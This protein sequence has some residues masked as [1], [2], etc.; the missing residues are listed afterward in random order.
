MSDCRSEKSKTSYDASTTAG[1][2]LTLGNFFFFL[3]LVQSI[4]NIVACG[5][6][7]PRA[8]MRVWAGG[9]KPSKVFGGVAGRMDC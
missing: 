5:W 7:Y 2:C 8:L 3:K 4:L 6:K 9:L 1:F